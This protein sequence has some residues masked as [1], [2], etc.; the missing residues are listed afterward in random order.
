MKRSLSKNRKK[1]RTELR[2][3]LIQ[4]RRRQRKTLMNKEKELNNTLRRPSSLSKMLRKSLR[5]RLT[6]SLN[7]VKNKLRKIMKRPNR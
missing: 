4:W 6:R 7:R 1:K 2:K 3:R 5:K